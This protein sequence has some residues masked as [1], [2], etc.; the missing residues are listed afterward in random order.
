MAL[1]AVFWLVYDL[2][3]RWVGFRRN[4]EVWIGAVMLMT[5]ALAGVLAVLP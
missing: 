1:L 4:G 3:C 2:T 5:L